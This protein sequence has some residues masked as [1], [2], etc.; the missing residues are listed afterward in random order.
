MISETG[1]PWHL[2]RI[3]GAYVDAS[4]S[5]GLR[6][7]RVSMFSIKAYFSGL[8]PQFTTNPRGPGLNGTS[9]AI[10]VSMYMFASWRADDCQTTPDVGEKGPPRGPTATNCAAGKSDRGAVVW[11]SILTIESMPRRGS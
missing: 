9:M 5:V 4:E 7:A 3:A 6:H 11:V 8:V 1:S 10:V 2:A